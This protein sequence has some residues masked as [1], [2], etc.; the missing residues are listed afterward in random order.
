MIRN[1][2]QFSVIMNPTSKIEHQ[3]SNIEHQT[4]HIK[5][6]FINKKWILDHRGPKNPVDRHL[7]YAWNVEKERTRNGSIE[8]VGTIFL[9]NKE[10]PFQCLMCDLW[11]NTTDEPVF[12]GA[13]PAQIEYALERM[14]KV[15]HLKLYN[16]GS[17]FDP[18]AI[19]RKDYPAIA[20]LLKDIETVIVES[21][22]SFIDERVIRFRD[23]LD[24][25]LQV[26]IGLETVHP[27]ILPLLNKRMSADDFRKSV[28][29]LKKNNIET[30]AFILHHLPFI[31]LEEGTN[32][33]CKSIDF[34]FDSG[35]ECCILIPLRAG[36]GAM[37]FLQQKGEFQLPTIASLESALEY[38]IRL[39]KGR[40]FADLW[41]LEIFSDCEQCFEDREDRIQQM[42]LTQEPQKAIHCNCSR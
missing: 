26:A 25:E 6:A 28:S 7:P 35:V 30:R 5:G 13:I 37:D 18:G 17:F 22:T 2:S 15:K 10:C 32:W 42:N 40:V 41:D 36:N 21:H 27:K 14:P 11:K 29:F 19:P 23:I 20:S 4:S 12:P 16:S 31:S 33:T 8:D 3:G 9:T 34:A 39:K 24:A 38:G 1:Q